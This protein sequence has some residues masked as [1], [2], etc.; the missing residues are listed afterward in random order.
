ME[1]DLSS[2]IISVILL[3]LFIAPVIYD[4]LHKKKHR[5]ERNFLD[6]AY[7]KKLS[8]DSYDVRPDTWALGIDVKAQRLLYL[9]MNNGDTGDVINLHKVEECTL[10]TTNAPDS[11]SSTAVLKLHFKSSESP[12]EMVLT[13]GVKA[14]ET[15]DEIARKWEALINEQ[16]A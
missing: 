5:A 1:V 12:K 2:V 15:P 9:N 6:R 10:I 4:Q 8:L 16:V 7:E 14:K 13:G 3:S 11:K